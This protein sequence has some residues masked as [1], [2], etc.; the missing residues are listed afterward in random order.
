[1]KFFNGKILLLGLFAVGI[2]VLLN[3]AGFSLT[4]KNFFYSFSAPIESFFWQTGNN[5]SDFVKGFWGG[6]VIKKENESL[7]EK[8]KELLSELL[9]LRDIKSENEYLRTAMGI[10]LE[11]EFK[12]ILANAVAKDVLRDSILI[13]KGLKDG[14]KKNQPVITGQKTLLGKIGE[15]Y[16]DFSEVILISSSEISFDAKIM[17]N[18]FEANQDI[19]SGV[20]KGKGRSEMKLDFVSKDKDLKPG[21]FVVTA[22]L[23]GI[24]PEGVL[25]GEIQDVE[26]SD[27]E[28]FQSASVKPA[29]DIQGLERLFIIEDF[30]SL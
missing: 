26:K 30:K 17:K 19:V 24:F 27:T 5:I 1:M 18:E 14:I 25:A 16:D 3:L 11:K 15:V 9:R 21:D 29:F 28:F 10:K 13:N 7:K 6:Q 23:G 22:A 4:A 20:V 8:N 12:Y 2:F